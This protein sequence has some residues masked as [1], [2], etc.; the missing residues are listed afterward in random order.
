[1]LSTGEQLV[2]VRNPHGRDNYT[3]AWS[4]EDSRWNNLPAKERKRLLTVADDGLFW[5]SHKNFYF[6]FASTLMAYDTSNWSHSHFLKLNDDSAKKGKRAG[7]HSWCGPECT[8]H[9]LTFKS[10]VTQTVYITA[11]TWDP[12]GQST[13]CENYVT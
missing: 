1:M 8:R 5:M 12:R 11:H 9:E 3:G 4:D 6:S 2:Q 10:S 13:E 7:S